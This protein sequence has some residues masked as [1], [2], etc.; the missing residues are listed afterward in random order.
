MRTA[1]PRLDNVGTHGRRPSLPLPRSRRLSPGSAIGWIGVW[2]TAL[3]VGCQKPAGTNARAGAGGMPS[4]PLPSTAPPPSNAP[5]PNMGEIARELTDKGPWGHNFT[6]LYER[7]FGAWRHEPIRIFEIGIASGGSLRLWNAYF[8]KA[9]I[10]AIDI[11]AS[12]QYEN[13]RTRTFVA[14]QSNRKQMAK[15]VAAFGGEF[16]FILDDGGHG[17]ALQQISLGFLFKYVKVGGYYVIEDLHT[18]LVNRY[19]GGGYGADPDGENTTLRMLERY[20]HGM[21]PRFD[22]KYL[23]PEESAYLD[24]HVES[25]VTSFRHDREHSMVCLIRKR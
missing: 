3:V 24:E 5:L 6:D 1:F 15:A 23:L 25:M 14:D 17:V 16:D 10:F 4:T 20:I 8:D 22:S 21:P 7:F 18:S 12:K 19:P 11:V 2:A 13:A 9:S